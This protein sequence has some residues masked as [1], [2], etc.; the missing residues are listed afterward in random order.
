M[1]GEGDHLQGTHTGCADG[2]TSLPGAVSCL[3]RLVRPVANSADALEV[4]HGLSIQAFEVDEERD[5]LVLSAWPMLVRI[6]LHSVGN[7]DPRI[8][9]EEGARLCL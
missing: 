5:R 8:G 1:C 2:R 9:R 4:R 7:G 3:G 6:S